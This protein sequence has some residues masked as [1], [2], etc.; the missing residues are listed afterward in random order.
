M[1]AHVR[2]PAGKVSGRVGG[3]VSMMSCEEGV[4]MVAESAEY[5]GL[6]S[7]RAG[8]PGGGGEVQTKSETQGVS[9]LTWTC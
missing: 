2:G 8:D 6:P 3:C 1:H 9:G 5:H 7:A 4:H